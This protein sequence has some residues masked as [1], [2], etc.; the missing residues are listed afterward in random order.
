LRM[1]FDYQ[2]SPA[3]LLIRRTKGVTFGR[4]YLPSRQSREIR[5]DYVEMPGRP[6]HL[7]IAA[8]SV[9]RVSVPY[10]PGVDL[11]IQMA[12]VVETTRT[13]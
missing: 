4:L 12:V 11:K 3:A 6:G 1:R 2:K 10:S 13:G 8:T 9:S 7:G 5:S